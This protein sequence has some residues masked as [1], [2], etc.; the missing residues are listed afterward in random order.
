MVLVKDVSGQFRVL[1][2]ERD[3][4]I[5][6]VFGNDPV[7]VPVGKIT[8]ILSNDRNKSGRFQ[9]FDHP[10]AA[11]GGSP[12]RGVPKLLAKFIQAACKDDDIRHGFIRQALMLDAFHKIDDDRIHD[13]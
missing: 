10:N 2:D 13:R 5:S 4:Y 8:V 11:A 12:R 3:R 7:K 9:R 6:L 1:S